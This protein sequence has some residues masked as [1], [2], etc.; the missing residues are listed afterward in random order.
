MLRLIAKV[1][2]LRAHGIDEDE[3]DEL[4]RSSL[5]W[6]YFTEEVK[7]SLKCKI[8]NTVILRGYEEHYLRKHLKG[9]HPLILNQLVQKLTTSLYRYFVYFENFKASCILCCQKMNIFRIHDLGLHL[10]IHR[11]NME[12]IYIIKNKIFETINNSLAEVSNV[13]SASH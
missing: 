11:I 4:D 5:L 9:L 10:I 6:Q 7:Y 2:L 3:I 8:Y 12:T 13:D 1:H